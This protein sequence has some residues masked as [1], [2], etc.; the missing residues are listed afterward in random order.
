MRQQAESFKM[1]LLFCITV[2]LVNFPC[3]RAV[4]ASCSRGQCRVVHLKREGSQKLS[5]CSCMCFSLIVHFLSN[6]ERST[7]VIT[8]R[9][10]L[11]FSVSDLPT[12]CP[13]PS[14]CPLQHTQILLHSDKHTYD[15][16]N[17][18]RQK[19]NLSIPRSPLN[20]PLCWLWQRCRHQSLPW[21]RWHQTTKATE[22]SL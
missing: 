13:P 19:E 1:R 9:V 18:K 3:F 8:L 20:P 14:P 21:Q 5:T 17:C 2:F 7:T 12:G 4:P 6:T 15:T 10:S 11:S 16:M 22:T